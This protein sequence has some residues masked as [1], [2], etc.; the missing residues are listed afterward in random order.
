MKHS[1]AILVLMVS[2]FLLSQLIGLAVVSQ[3]V[4][5]RQVEG[6]TEVSVADLP[7]GIERPAIYDSSAAF[8]PAFIAVI[9]GTAVLLF[10]MR[11]GKVFLFKIWYYL[12]VSIC[13]TIAFAAFLNT[14]VA[15]GLGIAVTSFK[16]FRPNP[17]VHNLSEIFIY[18]GLAAIFVPMFNVVGAVALLLVMSAYDI[19]AVSGSKHMVSLARFQASSNVFAGLAI[20]Y[21]PQKGGIAQRGRKRPKGV[22]RM[23]HAPVA[24][25]GGGDMGLPLLFAGVVMKEIGLL[26]ALVIPV[27]AAV[28]LLLLLY[29]GEK[30]KFYPAMPFITAG[31]LMGYAVIKVLLV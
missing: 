9:I 20:P 26:K 8:I 19:Y 18:G 31:C 21:V 4:V 17:I 15:A 14:V 10:L 11:L 29:K 7:L 5:V 22:L 24:V 3:Y 13:L 25:L 30:G 12:A 27:F 16:V 6:K 2:F 1:P 23:Q 28:A